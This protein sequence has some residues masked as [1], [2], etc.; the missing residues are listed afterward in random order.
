[1]PDGSKVMAQTKLDTLVLQL[2]VGVGLITPSRKTYLLRNFIQS[3]GMGIEGYS[4]V[5]KK[6]RFGT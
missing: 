1:M 3:F 5:S 2:W 4:T 6:F